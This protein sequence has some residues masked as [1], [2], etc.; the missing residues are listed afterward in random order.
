MPFTFSHPAIVLPLMILPKKWVSVT[1]LVVG[2]L[3][4]DFEYFLR[5]K[6]Q[7]DYSH[8]LNG[9]FWFDIPLG[10]CLAYI[11]HNYVRNSLFENLPAKLKSRLI[12]FNR[13]DWNKYFKDNL[14]VIVIS[15]FIGII[16]HI[17]WDNF[18]HETGYFVNLFPV[19]TDK[20]TI[21]NKEI[22]VYNLLQHL[23]TLIGGI[24]ICVF[25]FELPSDNKINSKIDTKYWAI[26]I[27]LTLLIISIKICSGL[28]FKEFGN[29]IVTGISSLLIALTLTPKM[30]EKIY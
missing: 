13:F 24:I 21:L 22:P 16:S 15:L 3:T 4:P 10:I 1:G 12:K 5:M 17:F 6:I 30:R 19:L 28:K 26:L 2:S 23:S 9:I 11:F 27:L 20:L 7:S 25:L 29:L 14:L 18:T 8:S